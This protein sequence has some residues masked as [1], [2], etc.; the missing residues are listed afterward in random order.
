MFFLD[1][2][3]ADL[4]GDTGRPVPRYSE[5]SVQPIQINLSLFL[6]WDDQEENLDWQIVCG[7]IPASISAL[8]PSL[9]KTIFQAH[10]RFLCQ[11]ISGTRS[12]DRAD[13]D[14]WQK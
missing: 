9:M 3:T 14:I 7:I 2:Q 6:L 10:R 13:R 12:I 5:P 8:N 1:P 4:M 11:L